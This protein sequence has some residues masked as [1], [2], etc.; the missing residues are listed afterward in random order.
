MKINKVYHLWF[1]QE[2]HNLRLRLS[3]TL[4][5]TFVN[6]SWLAYFDQ[7]VTLYTRATRAILNHTPIG[8]NRQCFFSTEYIQCLHGHCQ[9]ET[10]QYIFANYSRFAHSLLVDLSLLIENFVDFSKKYSSVFAFSLST[11]TKIVG[12]L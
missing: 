12:Y 11:K 3:T 5:I 10:Y 2:F 6:G 4:N 8:E 1:W 9:V 7:S